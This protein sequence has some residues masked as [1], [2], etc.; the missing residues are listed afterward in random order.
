MQGLRAWEAP[1][2]GARQQCAL[3]G[4]AGEAKRLLHER[5]KRSGER[6]GAELG[7][8]PLSVPD[9]RWGA[10]RDLRSRSDGRLST[11]LLLRLLGHTFGREEKS[12]LKTHTRTQ[13]F[14]VTGL[15]D[16]CLFD[17]VCA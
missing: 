12:L 10:I 2:P 3:P 6:R 14:S 16:K 17:F 8:W 4:L 5:T 9:T 11:D 13:N 7:Q 1:G 15:L